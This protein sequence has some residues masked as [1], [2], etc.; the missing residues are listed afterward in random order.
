MS[1]ATPAKVTK[2]M[3]RRCSFGP[4][5]IIQ[6]AKKCVTGLMEQSASLEYGIPVDLWAP[7]LLPPQKSD[8]GGEGSP[9]EAAVGGEVGRIHVVVYERRVLAVGHIFCH[10]AQ[11]Q[12]VAAK[13]KAKFQPRVDREK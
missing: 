3:S 9:A 7:E 6:L 5:A 2:A 8:S 13:G 1:G 4:D 11:G 10:P 12:R